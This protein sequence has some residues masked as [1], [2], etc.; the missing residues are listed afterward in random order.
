MKFW[1]NSLCHLWMAPNND[2]N[3]RVPISKG[4]TLIYR[5]IFSDASQF[6]A[7][8]GRMK[9]TVSTLFNGNVFLINCRRS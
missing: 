4:F 7:V 6:S 5:L 9:R 3:G 1:K 2:A 8:H